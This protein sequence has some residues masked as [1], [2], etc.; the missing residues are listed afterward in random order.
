M[1]ICSITRALLALL[2]CATHRCA[3]EIQAATKKA[4]TPCDAARQLDNLAGQATATLTSA[5]QKISQNLLTAQRLA[6]AAQDPDATIATAAAAIATHFQA[7]AAAAAALLA[8]QGPAVAAGAAALHRL[9]GSQLAIAALERLSIK[10]MPLG[11]PTTYATAA[12]QGTIP[13]QLKA[14]TTQEC[15][16]EQG[17]WKQSDEQQDHDKG[18]NTP[19]TLHTAAAT[20]TKTGLGNDFTFCGRGDGTGAGS[21]ATSGSCAAGQATYIAVNGGRPLTSAA[22]VTSLQGTGAGAKYKVISTESKIPNQATLTNELALVKI[23]L[24]AAKALDSGIAIPSIAN[25]YNSIEPTVLIAKALGGQDASPSDENIKNQVKTAAEA[26]F[27]ADGEKI[28]N[29]LEKHMKEFQPSKAAGSDGNK[30]LDSISDTDALSKAA[31]YYTIKN[32][33]DGEEQKKKNQASPS[34]PT[35]TEKP[36]E[37]KKTADECKKHKTSEDCKKETGCDF[38]DKKDP[39]CFPKVENDKKDEKSFSCN[40]RVPV[41]QVFAALVALLF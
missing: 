11:Q 2:I 12:T 34:C 40:L 19:I 8:E 16:T 25:A 6:V 30:K 7:Q 17:S 20:Q 37:P 39:K 3:A 22:E 27:G 13:P 29:K 33:I 15:R 24:D 36:E 26:L 10:D 38:D 28:K 32:F 4:K 14:S 18:L 1:E 9:A 5:T 21:K 41:P 31:A 35:K 23:M